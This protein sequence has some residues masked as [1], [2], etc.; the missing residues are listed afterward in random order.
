[1]MHLMPTLNP[2]ITV[3]LTPEVHA[4][5]RRLATLTGDSQSSIVGELLLNALPVFQRVIAT[6]EAAHAARAGML[7]KLSGDLAGAQAEVE[8]QAGLA[9]DTFDDIVRPLLQEA[10]KVTRRASKRVLTPRP[11]TRGVD[12]FT[13]SPKPRKAGA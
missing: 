10:E 3:T 11:V 5:M 8:R 13:P 1:M 9:L 6:M 2:R 12:S 7:G 4:V